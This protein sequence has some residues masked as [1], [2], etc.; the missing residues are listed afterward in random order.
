MWFYTNTIEINRF[1]KL[2]RFLI[3]KWPTRFISS[4]NTV[5]KMKVKRN[6]LILVR[7]IK[8]IYTVTCFNNL[9]LSYFLKNDNEISIIINLS[10][11][12]C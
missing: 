3:I 4:D 9:R 10:R 1:D 8:V 6:S 11:K 5:N 2:K 12:S 7:V